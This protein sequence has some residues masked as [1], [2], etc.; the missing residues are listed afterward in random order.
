LTDRSLQRRTDV[1]PQ[2]RVSRWPCRVDP[3]SFVGL[4][5][6]NSELNHLGGQGTFNEYQTLCRVPNSGQQALRVNPRATHENTRS[7]IPAPP[8]GQQTLG[9]RGEP[10]FY[11]S[12]R[13]PVPLRS[14][15]GAS[16]V[17][18]SAA[19]NHLSGK[20]TFDEGLT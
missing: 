12:A 18:A 8:H 19:A 13:C 15:P 14:T 7:H 4:I 6:G 16:G 2:V 10:A 20:G 11:R 3:K 5:L 17:G 9:L 1:A